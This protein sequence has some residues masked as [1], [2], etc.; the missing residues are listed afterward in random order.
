MFTKSEKIPL[1][2]LQRGFAYL[3][4]SILNYN[5]E[6][7]QLVIIPNL[8][9]EKLSVIHF[10]MSTL[11]YVS[12]ALTSMYVLI[13]HYL[14]NELLSSPKVIFKFAMM[15]VFVFILLVIFACK[16]IAIHGNAMLG[17]NQLLTLKGRLYKG[18]QLNFKK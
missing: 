1:L 15:H 16:C 12:L 2:I 9:K 14:Q 5:L 4:R 18:I 7:G 3:P 17:F 13:S 8:K 6:K 10:F 11:L